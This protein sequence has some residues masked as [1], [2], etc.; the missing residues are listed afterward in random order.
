MLR[1]VERRPQQ[2]DQQTWKAQRREAVRELGRLRTRRA[3]PALLA[4]VARER[5]DVVLEYAITALGEI[6]D[7]RAVGPLQRLRQDKA[8]DAYVREAAARALRR[9]GASPAVKP[10]KPRDTGRRPVR[11]PRPPPKNGGSQP[12]PPDGKPAVTPPVRRAVG[13]TDPEQVFG[14]LPALGP[15]PPPGLL[16]RSISWELVAGAADVRWDSADQGTRAGL[17]AAGRFRLQQERQRL[18]LT[19]AAGAG[20]GLRVDNPGNGDAVWS[21]NHDLTVTPEV[22]LYPFGG[23]LSGLFGQLT[24]SAGYGLVHASGEPATADTRLAAAGNLSV[25]AGPGFGRVLDAGPRLRL[26]RLLR[27]LREAGLVTMAVPRKIRAQLIHAW[28]ALRN[29]QGSHARLGH[30]LA[31]LT[32]AGLLNA[33][34]DPSTTYRLV[35]VLDDPQLEQRQEG[36][37]VRLGFGYART[38]IKDAPDSNNAF[39]YSAAEYHRQLGELHAFDGQL[40]FFYQTIG[41]PDFYGVSYAA[42]YRYFLYSSALDPLGSIS[43]GL[44]GGLSNQ[45]GGVFADRVGYR[46]V[47]RGAYTHHFNRGSAVTASLAAGVDTGNPLLLFNLELRWGLWRGSFVAP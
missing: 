36:P 18:G 8:L 13:L 33:L 15:A 34:S 9:I 42:T 39:L 6:R 22:R 7:P 23:R 14:A 47:A 37:L 17:S 29:H 32:R 20:L 25:A 3:V 5:F 45:P 10:V 1:L 16:M 35:R 24:A 21:M 28:Y 4:I 26:R 41:D 38:L 27:V 40:R 44:S 19:V 2:M 46:F 43:A 11:P 12:A 30:T 31:I